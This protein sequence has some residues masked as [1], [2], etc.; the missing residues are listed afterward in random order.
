M[1]LNFHLGL[2]GNEYLAVSQVVCMYV[3]C[4]RILPPFYFIVFL[5]EAQADLERQELKS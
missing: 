2:E 5:L 4:M 1:C 3:V